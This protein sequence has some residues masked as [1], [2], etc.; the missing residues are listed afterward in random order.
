MGSLDNEC[1]L[2]QNWNC[3]G[4]NF[5]GFRGCIEIIKIYDVYI[6]GNEVIVFFKLDC[7]SKDKF[8]KN[9]VRCSLLF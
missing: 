6:S 8:S 9:E 5:V 4:K 1:V 7:E 2:F 3:G